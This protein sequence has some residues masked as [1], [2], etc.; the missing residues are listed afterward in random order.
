VQVFNTVA[1][2]FGIQDLEER[3]AARKA[4]I[5]PGGE[6]HNK[7]QIIEKLLASSKTKY[8]VSDKPTLADVSLFVQMSSFSSGCVFAMFT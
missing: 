5:Q 6:T 4:L 2:T 7:M 1:P 8:Y 3:V